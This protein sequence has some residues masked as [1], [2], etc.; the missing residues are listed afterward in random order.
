MFGKA[1]HTP[2]FK[3]IQLEQAFDN[4]RYRVQIKLGGIAQKR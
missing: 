4:K 2:H 1:R 3:G